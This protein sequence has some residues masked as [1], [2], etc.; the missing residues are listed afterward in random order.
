MTFRLP[1]FFSL[2]LCSSRAGAEVNTN[3]TKVKEIGWFHQVRSLFSPVG[4]VRMKSTIRLRNSSIS[5]K[6]APNWITIVY[7]FQ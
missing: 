3:A 2:H 7:I 1:R 4:K 5:A 6:I